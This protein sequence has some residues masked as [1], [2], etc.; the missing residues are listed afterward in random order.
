MPIYRLNKDLIFPP[1]NLAS[2]NGLLA[3]GGDMSL[4]RIILAYQNG[5]FPWPHDNLPLLW[6]CPHPRF[7]LQPKKIIISRTLKKN[8][9]KTTLKI[10]ADHDFAKT[11]KHCA[12]QNR[13]NQ[14]GSW[15]T[16][17][18]IKSYC[19]LN[20]LGIAHSIEA[21]DKEKLVGGLYGV[22]LGRIFFGESMFTK[23]NNASKIC[24]ATLVA[25]LVYWNFD[26]I[27]CQYKTCNLSQFGAVH[28]S[29]N[30]F[31]RLLKISIKKPT[32]QGHWLLE[33]FPSNISD[34][35]ALSKKKNNLELSQIS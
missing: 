15:I 27:D 4:K 20:N 2:K 31:L 18:L 26:L 1:C 10:I 23:Q 3:I 29:R 25:N 22:S 12:I 32:K 30:K 5:I 6:F 13:K 19:Q 21:Y 7:V 11:I 28:W 17:E 33:I 9:K 35:L 8:L 34:K 16:K 24:F 14:H